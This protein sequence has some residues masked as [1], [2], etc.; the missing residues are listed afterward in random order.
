MREKR[1]LVW[2]VLSAVFLVVLNLPLPLLQRAKMGLRESVAPIQRFIVGLWRGGASVVATMRSGDVPAS[3]REKLAAELTRLRN[4]VSYLK[5][6]ERANARLREQLGFAERAKH[7]LIPCEVIARGD[8]SS[9]WHTIRLGKGAADGV[10]PRQAAITPEGLVGGT[11]EVSRRTCD[12]L[13][14]VDPGLKVSARLPRVDTFGIVRGAGVSLRGEPRCRI[15]FL[16]KNA[17]VQPGDKV[18]TSGLGG[19]F[20]PRLLVGYI[21]TVCMAPSGL[22]KYADLVPAADLA[23][24]RYV[25]LVRNS[26]QPTGAEEPVDTDPSDT[27]RTD[28]EPSE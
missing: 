20:P 26:P 16:D 8:I 15:D 19:L 2:I 22:Y 21:E 23:A 14:V 1:F 7:A 17:D 27:E 25:F 5:S 9:W 24:L 11:T 18:L 12:V 13:L 3:E 28:R 10:V 6:L 4:E